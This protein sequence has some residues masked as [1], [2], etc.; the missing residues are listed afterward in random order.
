M[1]KNMDLPENQLFAHLFF[2]KKLS[3]K[4]SKCSRTGENAF[5]HWGKYFSRV[6][7]YYLHTREALRDKNYLYAFGRFQP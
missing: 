2:R 6:G 7:E 4:L 5:V 3:K 1:S